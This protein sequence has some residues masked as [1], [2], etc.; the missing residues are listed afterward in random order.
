MDSPR[1]PA[2]APASAGS[3]TAGQLG[4]RERSIAIFEYGLQMVGERSTAA[5]SVVLVHGLWS[6]PEDWRWVR[7][8]LDGA[9]LQVTCPDLPSHRT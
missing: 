6:W 7:R 2:E 9:G 5:G 4:R 1:R 8:L 3:A